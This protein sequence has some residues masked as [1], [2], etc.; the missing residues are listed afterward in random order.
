MKSV[1]R[2]KEGR[3]ARLRAEVHFAL[4]AKPITCQCVYRRPEQKNQYMRG[5]NSV[6]AV[7]IRIAIDRAKKQ[8][9]INTNL[10][11]QA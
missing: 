9:S 6:T 2:I 7:D 1:E 8:P 5:W 10:R 4:Q 11:G 3:R